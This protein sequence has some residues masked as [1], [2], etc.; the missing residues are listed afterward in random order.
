VNGSPTYN[1]NYSQLALDCGP[2]DIEVQAF[3]RAG[4]CGSDSWDFTVDCNEPDI[5]VKTGFVCPNPTFAFTITDDGAGVNWDSV[6]V[7]V[8]E[9]TPSWNDQQ[10]RRARLLITESPDGLFDGAKVGDSVTFTETFL[11]AD[12]DGFRIVIYNGN[13][14]TYFDDECGCEYY[15]YD[16]NDQ[17]V[18]DMVGNRTEIVERFYTVNSSACGE[19]P[20]PG[21]GEDVKPD[22]NPFDPFAGDV[23]TFQI[24]TFMSQGGGTVHA[25]VYDL[26][27]EKVATLAPV[28][29]G[30][31]WGGATDDGDKVAEGVYLV[32]FQKTG[33]AAGT[34]TSQAVKVVVKRAD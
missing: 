22:M 18:P 4:Y 30:F 12:Y 13:R 1:G 19:G 33:A 7:D 15:I 11:Q 26:T 14:T 31:A 8:Y 21:E 34:R 5:A 25:A 10:V 17:G 20:G 2:H 16:H 9:Y 23:V 28:A 3:N 27:G 29:G 32:H 6:Y 24:G